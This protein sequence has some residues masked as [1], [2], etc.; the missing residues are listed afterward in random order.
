MPVALPQEVL[1]RAW[2]LIVR[3]C[4]CAALASYF[5]FTKSKTKIAQTPIVTGNWNNPPV[6]REQYF[7]CRTAIALRKLA[8][9]TP[10]ELRGTHSLRA[11]F[12]RGEGSF[13]LPGRTLPQHFSD[14]GFGF[15][16]TRR[17]KRNTS[18]LAQL[19]SRNRTWRVVCDSSA[20]PDSRCY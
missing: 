3:A 20:S 6:R 2:T 19:G 14:G 5:S 4:G 16:P 1:T 12:S 11:T 13:G 17:H 10:T 7:A 18:C 8:P 15:V 9:L